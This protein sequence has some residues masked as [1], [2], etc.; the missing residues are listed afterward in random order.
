M[1]MLGV[2]RYDAQLPAVEAANYIFGGGSFSSRLMDKVRT[3]AGLAYS[4]Y[5]TVDLTTRRK[6]RAVIRVQTRTDA[7]QRVI[8]SITAEM[9]NMRCREVS[10]AELEQAKEALTNSALM[11]FADADDTVSALMQLEVIGWPSDYYETYFE[12][13]KAVSAADVLDVS[14]RLYRP[15]EL[16]TV[17]VGDREDLRKSCSDSANWTVYEPA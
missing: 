3:E 10:G 1:G 5:S 15:E 8:G 12:R 11:A 9:E 13:L 4:I 16:L 17:V 6:G 7:V 2:D 14:R